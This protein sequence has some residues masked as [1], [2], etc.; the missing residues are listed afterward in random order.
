MWEKEKI[1]PL[2]KITFSAWLLSLLA[3]WWLII[4]K[5]YEY[6][7]NIEN[8]TK[9]KIE[10]ITN[11]KEIWQIRSIQEYSK[12]IRENYDEVFLSKKTGETSAFNFEKSININWEEL[13]IISYNYDDNTITFYFRR[14]Y[15]KKLGKNYMYIIELFAEELNKEKGKNPIV[16]YEQPFI[17]WK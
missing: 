14:D 15:S 2:T 5:K 1:N 13:W 8:D 3:F 6:I 17:E 7:Y 12:K 16:N 9:T 4:Y 11:E 10:H